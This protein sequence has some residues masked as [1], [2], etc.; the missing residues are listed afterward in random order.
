M[1]AQFLLQ[2]KKNTLKVSFGPFARYPD[3]LFFQFLHFI[4]FHSTPVMK[5][6]FPLSQVIDS[7]L[8]VVTPFQ[9]FGAC[10]FCQ[11][12]A[13]GLFNSQKMCI[14]SIKKSYLK[15][16]INIF[17]LK[18]KNMGHRENNDQSWQFFQLIFS[19]IFHLNCLNQS[20]VDN[21][22]MS[23]HNS[24]WHW[25]CESDIGQVKMKLDM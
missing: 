22:M 5:T 6:V 13:F 1:L 21:V 7:I 14:I 4:F 18:K 23:L 3:P 24:R 12:S 2:L 10:F 20:A 11:N 9:F 17:L 25:S 8:T 19:Y 15:T 16:N